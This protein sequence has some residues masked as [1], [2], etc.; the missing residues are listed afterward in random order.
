VQHAHAGAGEE[1]LGREMARLLVALVGG[2]AASTSVVLPTEL[3][4]RGT[5]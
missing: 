1:Q 5:G 2:E 4:R 3:V